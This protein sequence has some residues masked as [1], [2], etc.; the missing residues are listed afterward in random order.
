MST[1]SEY[2]P[3][4]TTQ[5]YNNAL[6]CFCF[7]ALVFEVSPTGQW[8]K[9]FNIEAV[10]IQ[11]YMEW[12]VSQ[13]LS[14]TPDWYMDALSAAHALPAHAS[15]QWW[16]QAILELVL[17]AW[18]CHQIFGEIFELRELIKEEG[19]KAG[20]GNYFSNPFNA[21]D[22]L[23]SLLLLG[24]MALWL[25]GIVLD[26]TR[27]IDLV[28]TLQ[29]APPRPGRHISLATPSVHPGYGRTG[30]GGVADDRT[31]LPRLQHHVQCR[32]H[33][34]VRPRPLAVPRPWYWLGWVEGAGGGR[35]SGWLLGAAAAARA[36]GR[37]ERRRCPCLAGLGHCSSTPRWTTEWPSSLN[38]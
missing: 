28:R 7:L 15:S 2:S 14:Q 33:L 36:V 21:L 27:N 17:L 10:N 8:S 19:V 25:V 31:L 23:R 12:H 18:T 20:I 16:I 30:G 3:F 4:A 11:E 22:W 35:A 6:P 5:V 29:A 24:S 34:G 38:P 26:E 1:S 9:R 32:D 13:S 37:S